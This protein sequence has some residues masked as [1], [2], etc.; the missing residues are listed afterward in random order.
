M[1]KKFGISIVAALAVAFSWASLA[2]TPARAVPPFLEQFKAKYV[3]PQSSEAS[4]VA[5][6]KAVAEA[7]CAVCHV[8]EGKKVRNTYGKEIGKLIHK[9]DGK[10][11][12]KVKEALAKVET[13]KSKQGDDAAPT[14]GDIIKQGKLPAAK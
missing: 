4:D 1:S 3:K 9:Q 2:T 8:G 14:F 13:L 7:K 10:N 6:A 12:A 11:P 5:F